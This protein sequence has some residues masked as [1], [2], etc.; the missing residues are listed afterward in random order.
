M[1]LLTVVFER[2]FFTDICKPDEGKNNYRFIT[3]NN[4]RSNDKVACVLEK[5]DDIFTP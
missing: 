4:R 1:S 5:F 3:C 2:S